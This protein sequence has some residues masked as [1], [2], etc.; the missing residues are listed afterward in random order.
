[1]LHSEVCTVL[2]GSLHSPLQHLCRVDQLELIDWRQNIFVLEMGVQRTLLCVV[3]LDFSI[4]TVLWLIIDPLT[5]KKLVFVVVEVRSLTFTLI[6]DPVA[7]EMVSITLSQHTIAVSF[8]FVPLAFI[9]VFIWI[10]HAT[11][12]LWHTVNP[13]TVVTITIFVEEGTTTMLFVLKP[14][15]SVFTT[16]FF[17]P[18]FSS[19][20]LDHVVCRVTTY[21]RICLLVYST[22]YRSLLYSCHASHLRTCWSQS[23]CLLWCYHLHQLSASVPRK[24]FCARHSSMP[25]RR[26]FSRNG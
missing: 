19:K 25:L 2:L 23:I 20:C 26:L 5:N 14:V 4:H 18:P 24:Q 15:A 16:K 17:C 11:F 21:L 22:G 7:F 6:V 1:M 8:C 13:V 3:I 10:D 12:S 9:N